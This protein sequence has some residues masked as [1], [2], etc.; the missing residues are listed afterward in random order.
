MH[1]QSEKPALAARIR[2]LAAAA[3]AA[4]TL[5]SFGM[6]IGSAGQ[7]SAALPDDPFAGLE[8]MNDFELGSLRGGMRTPF[9]LN[10]SLGA[11]IR[12]LIDGQVVL[13]TVVTFNPAGI[14]RTST[15]SNLGN[16]AAGISPEVTIAI[17][18]TAGGPPVVVAGLNG[19]GELSIPE[20]FEGVIS[21]GDNGVVATLHKIDLVENQIFNLVAVTDAGR[22]AAQH[23]EL[24]ITISNFGNLQRALQFNGIAS[25]IS[26]ALYAASL[27]ALGN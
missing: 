27:R 13:E 10:L 23:L 7:A 19:G 5:I 24:S 18:N 9:G 17:G 16:L 11:R 12:S 2:R 20:G 8:P 3:L 21:L 26:N 22:S 25:Q 4:A 14:T 6:A 1:D 15:L